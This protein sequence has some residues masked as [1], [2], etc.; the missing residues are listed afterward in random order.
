MK[1]LQDYTDKH[2]FICHISKDRGYFDGG[3]AAQRTFTGFI[4]AYWEHRDL[5]SRIQN[6]REV[7]RLLSLIELDDGEY[8]RHP[9][10]NWWFGRRGTMSRDQLIP[11]II[12]LTLFSR[13]SLDLQKRKRRLWANLVRRGGFCWNTKHIHKNDGWKIPDLLGPTHWCLFFRDL[14][15]AWPILC[16]VDTLLVFSV[17]MRCIAALFDQDNVGD[18]L[19]LCNIL[20]HSNL[21]GWTPTA[22]LARQ[23]YSWWRPRPGPKGGERM[24][25]YAVYNAW[26]HYYR[27]DSAP[28]MDELCKEMIMDLI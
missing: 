8:V 3:D 5:D 6:A 7:E 22:F 4:Q 24:Q 12:C 2:G 11:I 16:L 13:Y 10:N 27:H 21:Q 19:N 23:L 17:A 25:G 20:F 14:I 28:P 18:D 1:D 15:L 9:D 26:V